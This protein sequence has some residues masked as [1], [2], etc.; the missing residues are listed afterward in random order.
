MSNNARRNVPSHVIWENEAQ[1]TLRKLAAAK[2]VAPPIYLKTRRGPDPMVIAAVEAYW[3]SWG[4]PHF[5]LRH[6]KLS[7]GCPHDE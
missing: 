5:A 2:P 7:T 1:R 4:R 3:A 6:A